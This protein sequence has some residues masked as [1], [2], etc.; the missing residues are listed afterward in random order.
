MKAEDYPFVKELIID[1]KGTIQKV[2]INFSDYQRLL[3]AME[4]E[5]LVLAMMEVKDETPL[6]L[7][8]ALAELEKE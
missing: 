8:E 6:N 3:E 2:V 5:G 7:D 4:D 1:T